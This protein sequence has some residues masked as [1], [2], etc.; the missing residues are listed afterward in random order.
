L[1]ITRGKPAPKG[2]AKETSSIPAAPSPIIT[3]PKAPAS[4]RN[5]TR[6]LL[7]VLDGKIEWSK[8]TPESRKQFEEMFANPEFLRQF[9]LS[10]KSSEWDPETIKHLY[11]GLGMF[12]Q[13]IGRVM[14]QLPP[15]AIESLGF[16]SAEKDALAEP[17]AKMADEYSGEFLKKHQSL[18]V[19]LG[20]FSAI[21]GIKIKTALAIAA[22]ERAR[23]APP[24][25]RPGKRPQVVSAPTPR[26]SPAPAEPEIIP[27]APPPRDVQ[28]RPGESL[29]SVAIP[30]EHMAIPDLD[31][32]NPL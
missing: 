28:T 20:V 12:Y 5:K 9:G 24:A 25:V 18:V 13:T 11:D 4:S 15:R 17:T 22:E 2:S 26:P 30:I 23:N 27:V 10:M 21:N 16:T 31:A 29:E 8:M 32:V 19:W 6:V 7:T 3:P 1:K 14:L